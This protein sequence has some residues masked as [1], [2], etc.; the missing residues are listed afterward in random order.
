[1]G[2]SVVCGLI[3]TKKSSHIAYKLFLVI[4]TITFFNELTCYFLKQRQIPTALF[5]NIFFYIRFPFLGQIF[6][7]IFSKRI[8]SFHYFTKSF[9]LIS[10]ILFFVC[11]H[12]YNG[13]NYQIHTI[14]F[15]TGSVFIIINCLFLF[16]E[17]VKDEEI[18]NPVDFPFFLISMGFFIFYLALSPFFGILNFLLKT[19]VVLLQNQFIIIKSLNVI[20]YSLI[21]FDYF[22]QW[23]RTKQLY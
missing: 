7:T 15:L 13:L 9:Y 8:K 2:L 12:L 4:L 17:S 19:N 10:L 20:L 5:Y 22:L 23:K 6:L 1:M 3:F 16:Y 11:F 21:S 18:I 14:Y